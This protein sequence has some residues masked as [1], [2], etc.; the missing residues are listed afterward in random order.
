MSSMKKRSLSDVFLSS[1]SDCIVSKHCCHCDTKGDGCEP[2]RDNLWS[3]S[4]PTLL[5]TMQRYST[6]CSLTQP[7]SS[8]WDILASSAL[9]QFTA[10]SS[11]I[12][13]AKYNSAINLEIKFRI[14]NYWSQVYYKMLQMKSFFLSNW[15]SPSSTKAAWYWSPNVANCKLRCS[16]AKWRPGS[17]PWWKFLM[18]RSMMP[19]L[20]ISPLLPIPTA[21]NWK[22][23]IK[24][25]AKN[26]INDN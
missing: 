1:L 9:T 14:L 6:K 11:S 4:K 7:F 3:T 18:H 5:T 19:F 2:R 8:S 16:S 17:K 20:N 25:K 26:N 24:L 23:E 10:V 12:C 13:L 21:S 15:Y 22:V